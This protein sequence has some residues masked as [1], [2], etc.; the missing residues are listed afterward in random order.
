MFSKRLL[1]RN[2]NFCQREVRQGQKMF[3]S[4]EPPTDKLKLVG[5]LTAKKSSKSVYQPGQTFLHKKFGYRGIILHPWIASVYERSKAAVQSSRP[6]NKFL[7]TVM[8]VETYYQVLIDMRDL[9]PGE[10]TFIFTSLSMN[11]PKNL[12]DIIPGV[13][14]VEHSNIIPY[15]FAGGLP[16]QHALF[17][18]FFDLDKKNKSF[19]VSELFATW[20]QENQDYLEVDKVYTSVVDQ[21]KI[22][23]IP[24]Y[25]G[26]K[27][28]L[29]E[30]WWRY[31]VLVENLGSEEVVIEER[32]WKI[33]SNGAVK[34]SRNIGEAGTNPILGPRSPVFFNTSHISLRSSSGTVRGHIKLQLVDGRKV[35]MHT[36]T[37]F[38]E[39]RCSDPHNKVD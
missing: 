37:F 5:Y 17:E 3:F 22:V 24:F 10:N 25:I 12:L 16:I 35:D 33:I 26:R 18:Y 15:K 23:I 27:E 39:S 6:R 14:Y 2:C 13:D 20:Q 36:P 31:T 30:Y 19:K 34:K 1:Q 28:E 9:S 11:D 4:I 29:N 7:G 32:H 38:L 8:N 21:I